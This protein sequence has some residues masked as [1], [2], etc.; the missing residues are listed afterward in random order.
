MAFVFYPDGKSKAVKNLG[1]LLRHAA[2]VERFE[3]S[4]GLTGRYGG[5]EGLL[6]A[7][8]SDG[9]KYATSF[10]SDSL[11]LQWLDRP[12]FKGA[13][14]RVDGMT[15]A[16]GSDDYWRIY[17]GVVAAKPSGGQAHG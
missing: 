16:I 5:G 9:R 3:V 1:W 15:S 8:L 10:A 17:A 2:D 6:N 11:M 7:V 14:I 13:V 12:V 4:T